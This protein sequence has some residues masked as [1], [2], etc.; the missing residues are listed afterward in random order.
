M[1]HGLS[2]SRVQIGLQCHKY[3]WWRTH[4][5]EAEELVP[6]AALQAVFDRGR[7]VGEVA[8]EY[9]PGGILI[10]RSERGIRG[11]LEDTQAALD[12][13]A[14]VHL[15]GGLRA[16]DVFCAVDILEKDEDGWNLIEVKSSTG[17][18]DPYLSDVAIQVHVLRGRGT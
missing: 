12:S 2:K 3:L 8:R 11:A 13:G 10:E 1:T 17:V 14:T 7:S 4:E 18:K 16:D 6:D 15:R 5:P 9:V